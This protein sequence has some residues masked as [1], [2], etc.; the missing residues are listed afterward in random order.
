MTEE[1]TYDPASRLIRIRVWGDDPISDWI[2]SKQE[3]MQ[4]H[5]MHGANRLLVDV[6]EQE[7]APALFDI[8]D[9][10]DAWPTTIWLAVLVGKNTPDDVAFLETVATRRRKSIRIFFSESE[11]LD[12]LNQP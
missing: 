6:R 7:V 4:L 8:L 12:W 1:V 2:V 3:V 5:E 11:A 9:F 10:G